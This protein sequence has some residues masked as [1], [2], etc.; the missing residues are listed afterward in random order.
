MEERGEATADAGDGDEGSVHD[1]ILEMLDVDP[2]V[3]AAVKDVVLDALTEVGDISDFDETHTGST[4]LTSISVAGF[5]GIGRQARLELYPAPGLTVVS[6]RNGSGKSSFA[7]ALELA[8]TGTSYRWHKRETLWAESWQNLHHHDPCAIRVGF[9]AEGTGPFTIGVDWE[10]G[11]TLTDRKSWTEA[12]SQKRADGTGG[13][14]WARPLELWR[15]VLSYDELGRLFDGGPSALYDAL[16]NLLGLEVLADAEKWLAAGLKSNKEARSRADEQRRQLVALLAGSDDERA[17]RA[18]AL[19]KKRPAPLDDV[20]ALATG[21]DGGRLVAAALTLL[22]ELEPPTLDEIAAAATRLRGAAQKAAAAA[23]DMADTTRHRVD[24]LQ[25]ALRFHEHAGDSDCPVCGQGRLD[26]DWAAQ[27]RDS[28][29]STELMLAEY[30]AATTELK[31]ARST[32]TALVTD[33]DAAN[34]VTGVELAA[35]ADYRQA[36]AAAQDLPTGDADLA[37]HLESTMVKVTEAAGAL[38][39]QAAD[40]L[41]VRES[42][43]GPLAAQLGAWV[44]VEEEARELDTTVKT[45]TAAKK[46]MIDHGAAFRN[47]RLKPVAA[48]AR[49]IWAKLRQESNVDLGEITLEGTATRRKAVLRGS[50]DGRPTKALSVMSQGELHALALALFLPRA[51]SEKSPFRFVVLDDPIQAMDPAKIDGFVHVLAEIAKTHEVIVFSHDDRLASVIRETGVD[52][53]LVEVVRE[54]QSRVIVRDNV[55]PATRQVNDI[56]ALV[57][58][59]RLSDDIKAKVLPGLFR[60]ALES[61]ARQAYFAKQ[62]LA[63]RG[64]AEFERE[65]LAAKKTRPRLA[66]TVLGDATADLSDWLSAKPARRRTLQVCNAVHDG[67]AVDKQ[68]AR[69]L[70]RTVKE[71]LALR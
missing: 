63:G 38:R 61:A 58:D 7:E 25:A 21:S 65:W 50:V 32:A 45:M 67:A 30:R 43:W 44:P 53:R 17:Q 31:Q 4:F 29:A 3:D 52:A 1:V 23:T 8:L 6:G 37:A 15:P 19:L 54:T 13:L 68:D 12:E 70:E 2:E 9:T 14:G 62:S 35:L 11:A 69:D 40:A 42:A 27:A 60:V 28:I 48:Q 46:W 39:A 55:N 64:R 36:R 47:L 33:L 16:A 49:N 22:T 71:V 10:P 18:I 41:K 66:L 20:L 59:G 5:R 26:G 24:V 51:T 56:F 34:E 57:E